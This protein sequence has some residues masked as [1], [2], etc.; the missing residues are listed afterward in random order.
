[1]A[2]LPREIDSCLYDCF[3]SIAVG[4]LICSKWTLKIGS[5]SKETDPTDDLKTV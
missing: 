1:M 2:V 4:D 5:T 3:K